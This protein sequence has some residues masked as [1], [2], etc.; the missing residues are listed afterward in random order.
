M[1]AELV[2]RNEMVGHEVMGWILGWVER[3]VGPF[4]FLGEVR[5]RV[6]T[7]S[8]HGRDQRA[9]VCEHSWTSV[10]IPHVSRLVPAVYKQLACA[11]SLSLNMSD[12]A[13]A[14]P[15]TSRR[16]QP[17]V[18]RTLESVPTSPVRF[19]A[20]VSSP[21]CPAPHIYPSLTRFSLPRNSPSSSSRPG[22][23]LL[24]SALRASSYRPS[25]D[26]DARARF[27][28]GVVN[29]VP[30]LGSVGGAA[31]SAHKDVDKVAFT[32]STV[33]GRKIMEAAAKSNLKKVCVAPTKERLV[34]A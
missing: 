6:G 20:P 28:P 2:L 27:P 11:L 3:N 8:G 33:T 23:V 10:F 14:S 32:G 26:P 21:F 29:T 5:R 12:S 4:A 13:F 30:S 22:M 18:H 7:L 9:V 17:L 15:W 34:Q 16:S 31:L 25:F 1:D 24:H 19:R